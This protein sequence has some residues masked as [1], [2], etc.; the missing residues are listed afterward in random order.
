MNEIQ[1][2]IIKMQY[3][4]HMDIFT[5]YTTAMTPLIPFFSAIACGI[6]VAFS[7]QD[8][9]K[10]EE[11]KLKKIVLF[12]LFISGIG[13]FVTFCYEFSPILFVWL[14]IACLISYISSSIFFYRIIRYLT[15]LGQDEHF[16][17][18]HYLL[19]G[20]LTVVML[21]WSLFIPFDVQLKIVTGKAQVFPDGYEIFARFYTIK[22]LLRVIFGLTYYTLSIKVLMNYYNRATRNRTIK[23]Q[24][25][26]WLFFLIGISL[27]SLFSS[28]L[29]TFMPRGEILYS[30]WTLI[31]ALSI[32]VQHV[33][34]SYHI[35]RRDYSPYI[36]NK[37]PQTITST[38]E[39]TKPT[40]PTEQSI[41]TTRRRQYT[42]KLDRKIFESF[43]RKEKPYLNPDYKITNLVDDLDVN[44][45]TLSDFVNRTYKMNFSR[46][47]NRMRLEELRKLCS[48]P[49]NE[50]KSMRSLINKVGFKDYRN[51]SRAATAEREA[52][53]EKQKAAQLKAEAKQ[54]A[55]E[56][57]KTPEEQIAASDKKK[58]AT[59][60][61]GGNA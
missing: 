58:R 5:T 60:K 36:I 27:A 22:P 18:I 43:M 21:T 28:V 16:S 53:A 59:K 29:P 57:Q 12:Y 26:Q 14:N 32:T 20:I 4:W 15:R 3:I 17:K 41:D 31:V 37:Q 51:Y 50:G 38:P 30:V 1:C 23:R 52:A 8:C 19:P 42:G 61:K 45:T 56:E 44:R 24:P 40:K 46:Y 49:A 35:I 7:Q 9:L 55:A 33:L 25:A 2:I 48:L 10:R 13:W 6:L 39:P 47:L 11:L 34:L 54:K